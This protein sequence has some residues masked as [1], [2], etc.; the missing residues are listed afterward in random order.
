M[1]GVQGERLLWRFETWGFDARGWRKST[2]RTY[3]YVAA[4]A[5]RWL[6]QNFKVSLAFATL[7]QVQ[8]YVSQTRP[9]I[10]NRNL[11]RHALAGF[12]DFCIA[13]GLRDDNPAKTLPVL[14]QPK[15][16]PKAMPIEEACRIVKA[17]H[18]FGPKIDCLIKVLAFTGLRHTP[19]RCL[20]WDQ[21]DRDMSHLT[22]EEKGGDTRRIPLHPDLVV[23]LRKWRHLCPSPEWVFPSPMG[24]YSNRPVSASWV[25]ARLDEVAA[26]AGLGHV[27]AHLFRHTFA[28]E[29][30]DKGAHIK[31][32][33][34]L[35]GHAS[36]ASTQVYLHVRNPVSKRDVERL[37]FG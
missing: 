5:D 31:S 7:R 9:T 24:I 25:G 37:D 20:R 29:L 17:A 18:V 4:A 6:R 34:E 23:A 12:F 11:T 30:L 21:L 8:A 13:E 10:R 36:L 27:H 15:S 3:R 26:M 28:T 22:V 1:S 33:Q 35:L 14:R 16:V 32:V 2:R 19:A